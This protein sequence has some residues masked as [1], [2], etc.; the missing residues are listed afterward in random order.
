MNDRQ[1]KEEHPWWHR[2][3]STA[4]LNPV[5][6]QQRSIFTNRS[7]RFDKIGAIG[8][9]FDHTLALYNCERLDSLAMKLVIDRLVE[10][11]NVSADFA[12]EILEPSFARKGL[13]VDTETGNVTKIDRYGHVV[14]AYH[15][16]RELSQDERRDLY[17]MADCI[18]NVTDGRRFIQIDSDFA[19]PEV[20]IYSALAPR[21][22]EGERRKLWDTIRGHTD[23][24]HR[25]GSLKQEL[26]A[27]PLHYLNP[28]LEVVPMLENLRAWGKKV[29]LLTNS[30]WPYTRP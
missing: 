5:F 7:L 12:D 4:L 9:D 14:A 21:I 6:E 25:D 24:I 28:D 22:K 26:M 13:T 29:F 2:L 3:V 11:E 10:H 20:L 19:K 1:T 27:K 15:G 30:E 16:T 17:G 8:F 23:K 18:P